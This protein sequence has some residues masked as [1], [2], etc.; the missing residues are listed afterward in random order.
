MK[1]LSIG[2]VLLLAFVGSVLGSLFGFGSSSLI[3]HGTSGVGIKASSGLSVAPA[4]RLYIQP[5]LQKHLH[6]HD[7]TTLQVSTN[8]AGNLPL[9]VTFD[10]YNQSWVAGTFKARQLQNGVPVRVPIGRGIFDVTV[11][12]ISKV[13]SA[14]GNKCAYINVEGHQTI[15]VE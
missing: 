9:R 14:K 13:L 15:V 5:R 12:P 2:A 6:T 7:K 8:L 10:S 1:S 3:H 11:H 4:N